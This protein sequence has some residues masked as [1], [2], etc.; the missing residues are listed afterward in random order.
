[1]R[2][3]LI[4]R[5]LQ[6]GMVGLG[7]LSA[8]CARVALAALCVVAGSMLG[9]TAEASAAETSPA[10]VEIITVPAVP[11][12]RFTFDGITRITDQLGVARFPIRRGSNPHT[13]AVVDTKIHESRRDLTFVRWWYP[14]N[15]EQD[16][17][18]QVKG[19]RIRENLR[20]KAAFRATYLVDYAF[21]DQAKVEV[22]R[23]RVTRIEFY[24]DNGHTVVGN[25]SGRLRMVGI[26]P[27]T[28]GGTILAKQV[29]YSVQRVDVDGSNVVQVNHQVFVPSHEPS[30]DIPLLLRTAHFSTRDFLFGSSVG[31]SV[32]LT[33]PDGQR[34]TVS[35]DSSGKAT[36]ENLAR[37]TYTVRVDAPGYS[38]DR[39]VALSRNQYIDLP[40]L[41]YLDMA[42]IGGAGLVFVGALYVLRFKTRRA[43]VRAA[44]QTS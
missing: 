29:N 7:R 11:R 20:I 17:L 40:V 34:K 19:I 21:T 3:L 36:V 1:M 37:G 6:S 39:P 15:H 8:T 43:H 28:N 33:Y 42:V 12:A 35:L 13:I 27:V 30:V 26:R 10:I 38:F 9:P 31:T 41:T 23:K 22:D 2:S 18:K 5:P 24:G 16:F 14:G 32:R 44:T 25:G 4:L